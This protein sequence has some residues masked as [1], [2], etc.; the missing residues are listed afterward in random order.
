MLAGATHLSPS[1]QTNTC[2]LDYNSFINDMRQMP[3][4]TREL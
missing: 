1:Q 4:L 2:Q 3:I